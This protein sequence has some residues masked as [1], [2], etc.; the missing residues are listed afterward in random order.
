LKYF[1]HLFQNVMKPSVSHIKILK[2]YEIIWKVVWRE[3]WGC[4]QGYIDKEIGV[5]RRNLVLLIRM[6]Q[7]T[8]QRLLLLLQTHREGILEQE[9]IR[10]SPSHLCDLRAFGRSTYNFC[11]KNSGAALHS[12]PS[13]WYNISRCSVVLSECPYEG[14]LP[15]MVF[16]WYWLCRGGRQELYGQGRLSVFSNHLQWLHDT[17]DLPGSGERDGMALLH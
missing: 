9:E 5:N 17:L 14:H 13:Q 11:L 6:T 7:N 8:C 4:G 1:C 12:L 2:E 15:W 10:V 3:H 16:M